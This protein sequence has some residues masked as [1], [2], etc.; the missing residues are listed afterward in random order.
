MLF[1]LELY[2]LKLKKHVI[3]DS[4]KDS[5]EVGAVIK[6]DLPKVHTHQTNE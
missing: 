3:R 6:G 4:R 5:E 1:M 2:V